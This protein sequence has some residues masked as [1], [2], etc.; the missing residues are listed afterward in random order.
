VITLYTPA[1]PEGQKA[2][3][4][5]EDRAAALT[6]LGERTGR[7]APSDG[8]GRSI[9]APPRAFPAGGVGPLLV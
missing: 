2:S 6:N 1:T 8:Q 7:H 9:V 4:A 3:I 5:L